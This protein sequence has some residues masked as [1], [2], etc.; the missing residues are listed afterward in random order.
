MLERELKLVFLASSRDFWGAA[1][2]CETGIECCARRAIIMIMATKRN[3]TS[4]P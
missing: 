2:L 1:L 3:M 4:E